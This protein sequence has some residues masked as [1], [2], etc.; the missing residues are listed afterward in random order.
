MASNTRAAALLAQFPGPVR[1]QPSRKK[2]V[3]VCVIGWLFAIGG[4]A[5]IADGRSDG[6]LVAGFFA[7]VAIVA[8]VVMLPNA[9]WLSLD[10]EGFAWRVMYRGFHRRWSETSNFGVV[11][12]PRSGRMV[13]Y[14]D[15][16]AAQ[17]VLS[18]LNRAM[19]GRNAGLSDTYGLSA[20]DLAALMTQWRERA[21][22][23]SS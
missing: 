17:G 7:F 20:D 4:G 10:A 11:A 1:L 21:L 9:S 15:A 16:T 22:S 12:M 2:W 3:L 18:H 19:S 8:G 14:D 6:W 23:P 13:V 5:M